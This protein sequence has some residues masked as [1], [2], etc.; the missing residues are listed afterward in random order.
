MGEC[1]ISSNRPQH[2]ISSSYPGFGIYTME[3]PEFSDSAF[4]MKINISE[5]AFCKKIIELILSD[6][7]CNGLAIQGIPNPYQKDLLCV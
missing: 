6:S 1:R 5:K 3:N 2:S 7:L 4:S